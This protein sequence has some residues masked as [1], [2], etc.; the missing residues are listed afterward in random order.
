MTDGSWEML[1]H[2][3]KQNEHE[4]VMDHPEA[5]VTSLL[6]RIE[7]VTPLVPKGHIVEEN[8]L[9]DGTEVDDPQKYAAPT[10]NESCE[11][12]FPKLKLV[13]KNSPF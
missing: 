11:L 5:V 12:R 7:E 4:P 2:T 10:S 9:K 1:I 13:K 8:I 6:D 3:R